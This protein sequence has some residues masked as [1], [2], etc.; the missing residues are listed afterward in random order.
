MVK[1]LKIEDY[2]FKLPNKD[3]PFYY[4]NIF[5]HTIETLPYTW[6]CDK[7]ITMNIPFYFNG[8]LTSGKSSLVDYILDKKFNEDFDIL[9]IK[10]VSTY[11]TSANDVE[12]TIFSHLNTIK[13]DLFGDKNMKEVVLYIDDL[14]MNIKKICRCST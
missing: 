9:K 11:F 5:I 6:L 12:N 4:G 10:M 13:R 1:S 7:F 8:K 3:D 2:Q 14:N